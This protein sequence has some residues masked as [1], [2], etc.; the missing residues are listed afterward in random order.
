MASIW[1]ES[2]TAKSG[3][4]SSGASYRR[5]RLPPREY[6]PDSFMTVLLRAG[7]AV[8]SRVRAP[9]RGGWRLQAPGRST[10]S[11][12][13]GCRKVLVPPEPASGPAG[14]RVSCAARVP[15]FR[16]R[17]ELVFPDPSLAHPSGVLAVGGDLS[18]ERLLLAY[19][20]G[21][22]PW[23]DDDQPLLWWSPDPRLVLEPERIHVP[24]SLAKAIRRGRT[25][26]RYDTAFARVIQ[27]CAAAPRPGQDG[28]WLTEDMVE[29]YVRLHELG[30]AHSAEAWH[31][32]DLVGGLYGVSLG[33]AF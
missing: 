4:R 32:D 27:A 17:K 22:F 15:I 14:P 21:I 30:W 7:A 31:G 24:R 8:P 18:P 1:A 13:R 28:T 9:A 16:L 12:G 33:G 19:A 6:S 29:A 20:S 3:A 2:P 26:V 10:A 11:R 23:F 5:S 25:R